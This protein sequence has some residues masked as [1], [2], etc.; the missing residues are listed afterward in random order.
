MELL[1]ESARGFIHNLCGKLENNNKIP[2]EYYDLY[3]VKRGLRN[4]DGTGVVAG[5]TKVCNVHGYLISEGERIPHDGELTYRGY[6]VE[7]LV[8]GYQAENRFGYEETAFLLL[9]GFLL[10]G[11]R[12]GAAAYMGIFAVL[13]LLAC[14]WLY[15]WLKKKGVVVFAAL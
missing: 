9:F 12:L 13:T 6:N 7:S 2:P 8:R 10:A 15:R 3:S 14:V 11:Q 1:D 5:I 4:A